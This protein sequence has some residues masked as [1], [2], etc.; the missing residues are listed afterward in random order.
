MS[1][2]LSFVCLVISL[3]SGAIV[4]ELSNALNSVFSCLFKFNVVNNASIGFVIIGLLVLSVLGI[5]I[6]IE[7]LTFLLRF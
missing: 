1:L 7:A 6:S 5:G 4:V 2:I 3:D